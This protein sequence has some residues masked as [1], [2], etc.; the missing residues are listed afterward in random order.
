MT[1]RSSSHGRRR[2]FYF[3]CVAYDHRGRTVCTNVL[4]LSMIA[5]DEAILTKLSTYAAS[6]REVKDRK[7]DRLRMCVPSVETGRRCSALVRRRSCV[8]VSVLAVASLVAG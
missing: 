8:S 4:P 2:F 6:N 3:I 5:A 7:V 1:V